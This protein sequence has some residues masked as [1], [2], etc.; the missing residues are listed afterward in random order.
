MTF[1]HP[2][3]LVTRTSLQI[4][5]IQYNAIDRVERRVP[6]LLLVAHLLHQRA[7]PFEVRSDR[8]EDCE[9]LFVALAVET[10][11]QKAR[12]AV[13]RT[14]SSTARSGATRSLALFT[15]A[16]S[17]STFATASARRA[18]ESCVNVGGFLS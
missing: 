1:E 13:H 8:S 7:E 11:F 10:L 2:H 16:V 3:N 12:D 6:D 18:S 4:A 17:D 15:I 5:D 9:I 14:P